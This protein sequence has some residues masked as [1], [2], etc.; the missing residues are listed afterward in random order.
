MKNPNNI[1]SEFNLSKLNMNDA[2]CEN[3]LEKEI[4]YLL[5]FDVDR[6]LY[7]F[8]KTVGADTKGAQPYNGWETHLIGGHTLG[9]YLTA[10]AQAYASGST[11]ESDQKKIYEMITTIIDELAL[12]Q[13]QD[14]FLWGAKVVEIN[15]EFQF[16]NVEKGK[17]DL[18]NEAWVPWYTMHK[19]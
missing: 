14:G 6:L 13:R 19:M 8:R 3:A 4:D 16:D 17:S 18:F 2:Y 15:V 12:C 11:S 5:S 1:I 9:H 7:H 10:L